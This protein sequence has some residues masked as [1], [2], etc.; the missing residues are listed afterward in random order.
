MS[1]LIADLE[2]RVVDQSGREYFVNV[3]AELTANGRWAAWL[4]FVP[5][6][7]TE[8]LLTDTETY[9]S[10]RE[11]VT[12]WAS[13]LSD[14]FVQGAFARARAEAEFLERRELATLTYPPVVLDTP[15]ALDPFAVFR[16]GKDTLR[17]RVRPL[18]RTE[19]LTII[20][21]YDLNPA[22]LSLARL[23]TA[24]LV[25]FIVTATEVQVLQGR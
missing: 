16:L 19:L 17:A 1:E 4:E 23:T 9:Q 3:A 8:P 22:Q 11:D 14:V 10:T 24:Q 13:T 20:G 21:E 25:T 15:A 18:T 6:D 12:H 5:L 7:N 2:L